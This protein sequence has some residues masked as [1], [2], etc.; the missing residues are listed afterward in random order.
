[1]GLGFILGQ[2]HSVSNSQH[3]AI[4]MTPFRGDV[5]PWVLPPIPLSLAVLLPR[6]T[7]ALLAVPILLVARLFFH[8]FDPARVRSG[9]QGGGDGLIRRVSVLVKPVT[10]VV[11][12]I[13]A[14][15]VPA[16]P[17]ALRPVLAETVMT[18]CQSPLVLLAW[19]AV[20][21]TTIVAP[22]ATVRHTL[23][24]VV[25]VVLAVAL[26]D[27]STRDRVAGMQ[28]MLYSMPRVKPDYALIK[29][30]A[31]L[32]LAVLFCL[33]PALRIALS[34]PASAL[35]LLIAA[36]FMAAL[37]TALGFLTRTPKTFMGVFMLFLYLVLNGATVP[38]LDFA[39]WNGVA[40]GS[41]RVGYLLAAAVLG[42]IAEGKH[43]WDVARDG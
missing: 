8:R 13:G 25:A 23:P 18:L 10:R 32:L 15:L 11:S 36:G 38:G 34:A 24:L 6:F 29:L 27:L 4:G 19:F 33:P 43:R 39:G 41:T 5:A 37:A 42:L 30:G 7:V 9:R 31:A 14:R 26:A 2:V 1:M 35:S 12:G 22:D 16:A 17:G 28:A 20:V 3:L 40:T 21:I